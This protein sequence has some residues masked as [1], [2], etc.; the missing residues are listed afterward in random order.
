M[1][2]VDSNIIIYTV[3]GKHPK[4]TEWF[5]TVDPVVSAI[6]MLEVLG[7]HRLR[8][9]EKFELMTLFSQMESIYPGKK[10]FEV[11]IQLRQSR[12]MSIGDSLIAATALQGNLPLATHNVRD[13]SWIEGLSVIDPMASEG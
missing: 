8:N 2:L 1:I 5:W 11:A 13:F 4:V 7:Y 12:S 3:S 9:K 10:I 6:S